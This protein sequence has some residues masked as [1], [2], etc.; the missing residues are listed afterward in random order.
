[1]TQE[2][3]FGWVSLS[4]Y[5]IT[6]TSNERGQVRVFYKLGLTGNTIQ[7]KVLF[8]KVEVNIF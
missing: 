4:N 1:M 3:D 5:L 7:G 6:G 2:H 8:L